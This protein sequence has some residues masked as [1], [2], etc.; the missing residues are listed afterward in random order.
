MTVS[1]RLFSY[2]RFNLGKN[3]YI[4]GHCYFIITFPLLMFTISTKFDIVIDLFCIIEAFY[5]RVCSMQWI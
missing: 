1:W 4:H 5:F 2:M 3:D